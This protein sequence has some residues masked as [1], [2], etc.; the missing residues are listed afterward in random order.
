[1]TIPTA[2]RP[3]AIIG[4]ATLLSLSLPVSVKAAELALTFA[5]SGVVAEVRVKSGDAVGKGDVLAVLDRRPL[6]ARK[7]A[8]DARIASA[9]VVHNLSKRRFEQIQELYDSLSASAEQV[10]KAEITYV[11]ARADLA[12]AKAKAAV[13][14][15]KLERATLTAPAAGSIARVPGYAGQV[16]NIHSASTQPVV[17]L[18]TL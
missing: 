7:L 10:E 3:I 16:V 8:A 13:Y 4:L 2:S 5:V 6:E 12:D 17:V 9:R 14:A 15:W 1:M 11:N 18:D